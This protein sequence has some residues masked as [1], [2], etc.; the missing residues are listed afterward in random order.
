MD[1]VKSGYEKWFGMFSGAG[2]AITVYLMFHAET[3]TG[4]IIFQSLIPV[5][6]AFL[7]VIIYSLPIKRLPEAQVVLRQDL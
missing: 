2:L 6:S 1:R 4:V 5:F 7:S 3:I